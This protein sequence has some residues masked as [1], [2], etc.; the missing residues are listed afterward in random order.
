MEL[1]AL[2]FYLLIMYAINGVVIHVLARRKGYRGFW[3]G[4]LAWC[5]LVNFIGAMFVLGLPD[6]V[7]REMV[8][9]LAAERVRFPCPYCAEAIL[10]EAVLC[11]YC[12]SDVSPRG[13]S[14]RGATREEGHAASGADH[15]A[16]GG[17]TVPTAGGESSGT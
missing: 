5:P 15:V 4:F 1:A 9:N 14:A 13:L 7:V 6:L 10:P 16:S 8:A 12:G 2:L 11:R 17:G 3:W